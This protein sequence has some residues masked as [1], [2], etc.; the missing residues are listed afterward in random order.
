MR[1]FVFGFVVILRPNF[2]LENIQ[3]DKFS[4]LL[5]NNKILNFVRK[6]KTKNITI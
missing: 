6:Q 5:K 1:F 4:I 2:N 3:K